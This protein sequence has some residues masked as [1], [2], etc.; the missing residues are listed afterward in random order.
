MAVE[1]V[2]YESYDKCF[3]SLTRMGADM[4]TLRRILEHEKR[5]FE[6]AVRLGYNPLYGIRM[7]VDS[8][9]AILAGYVEFDG[10]VPI[11]QDMIDILL[12]PDKPSPDDLKLVG[13]ILSKP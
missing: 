4:E 3:E 6:K 10:R 13:K 12:A 8:P 2:T 11:G 7:V 1:I 9:P 5:H